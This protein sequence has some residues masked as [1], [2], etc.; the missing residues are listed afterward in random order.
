MSRIK[1]NIISRRDPL[2]KLHDESNFAFFLDC[3]MNKKNLPPQFFFTQVTRILSQSGELA[4]K[5]Q[6]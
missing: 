6:N 3:L 5:S 4:A 1:S 2:T